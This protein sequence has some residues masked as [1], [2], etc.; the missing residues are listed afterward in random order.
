MT[1][2]LCELPDTPAARALLARTVG[3]DPW[4]STLLDETCDADRPASGRRLLAERAL[5]ALA[6]AGATLG[7]VYVALELFDRQANFGL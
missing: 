1:S 5:T 4:V 2:P 7:A 3:D 6:V